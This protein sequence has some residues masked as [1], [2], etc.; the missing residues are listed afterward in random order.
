MI[1]L[2]LLLPDQKNILTDSKG[3]M[4]PLVDFNRLRL[5]AWMNLQQQHATTGVSK[6]TFQSLLVR[7]RKGTYLMYQSRWKQWSSWCQ[8]RE[9]DPISCEIQPFL[10]FITSLFQEGLQDC[11]I[12]LI[13]STISTTHLLVDGVPVGQHP[14]V[15]QLFRGVF[16]SRPPQPTKHGMSVLCWITLHN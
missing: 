10:D 4:H 6:E 8:R 15:K 1:E 5:A 9:V 16:N 12:N 14:L 3:Q 7:W 2:P 11:S 13:C